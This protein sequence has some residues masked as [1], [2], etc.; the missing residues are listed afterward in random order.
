[1]NF[2]L[3]SGGW[4]RVLASVGP[5]VYNSEALAGGAATILRK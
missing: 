3:W 1:M 5:P 2:L 4:E